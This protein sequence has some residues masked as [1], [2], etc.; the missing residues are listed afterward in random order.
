[1]PLVENFS[2]NLVLQPY[3]HDCLVI[4]KE[5]RQEHRFRVFF[6]N[7]HRL[8]RNRSLPTLSAN[9]SRGDLI[10]MRTAVLDDRSVVNWRGRDTVVS[11]YMIPR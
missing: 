9:F 4:V 3:I 5:G 8:P 10:V 7:H 2:H 6:K 1:M 11:D